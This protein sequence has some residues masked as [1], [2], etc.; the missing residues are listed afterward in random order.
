MQIDPTRAA[1][2]NRRIDN[3]MLVNTW[4]GHAYPHRTR[5][6]EMSENIKCITP[7]HRPALACLL[8]GAALCVTA[9][10]LDQPG[11]L[12]AD[13]DDT[14]SSSIQL[15]G[16]LRD[17]HEYSLENGHPDFEVTPEGGFGHFM[18]NIDPVI[19]TDRK[20]V[21][22]GGGFK[23]D[24]QWTDRDGRPIC[25]L[26]YDADLGDVAGERGVSSRGGIQS[27]ASL[28][29]WYAD[30]PGLNMSAPLTI[31][32]NKQSDGSYVF[33]DQLDP[34][35]ANLGGFFPLDGE[36][37]GNSPGRPYHNYHFTFEL[38]ATFTYDASRDQIFQFIGDDDVW[39]YI[40]GR[41]VIDLNGIHA[42]E[43][44]YVDLARLGLEDGESYSLD[45][46]FAERHRTQ[47]NFRIVTNLQLESAGT[48]AI[49]AQYD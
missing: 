29:S 22:T 32:F 46:F 39:C 20:P 3:C 23:V 9:L 34:Q 10:L 41:L 21:F 30:V 4:H 1:Q 24:R 49:T 42:A 44:Q 6:E 35:Y 14:E 47:S 16:T 31:T 48:P 19:G 37:F 25:Y 13:S 27:A 12:H 26:L 15:T 36:L 18:G 38:H 43:E 17:F 33:D 2:R 45:F 28:A 7:S 8:T 5:S 11:S 40:D